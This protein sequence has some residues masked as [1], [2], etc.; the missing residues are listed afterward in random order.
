MSKHYSYSPYG[1]TQALGADSTNNQQY[2][3]REAGI[4]GEAGL[5]YYRARYYDP[6]LK[7]FISEDP[8]GLGGGWNVY[9]YVYADPVSLV[10]PDGLSGRIPP[11]FGKGKP[12][13]PSGQLP[14]NAKNDR[15]AKEEFYSNDSWK[16]LFQPCEAIKEIFKAT[17]CVKYKC[18]ACD[19][20]IFETGREAKYSSAYNQATTKCECVKKGLRPDYQGGP[21]PGLTP[22]GR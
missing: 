13:P 12:L 15:N 7:R 1:Q 2:T 16:C 21:P 3:G 9:Q 5:Y 4:E 14:N 8:I 10:D 20:S 6:V 11:N 17:Y 22:P 18:V 19:G